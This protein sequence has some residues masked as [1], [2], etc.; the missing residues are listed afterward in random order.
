M[1]VRND[2]L[3]G[4]L[5]FVSKTQDYQIYGALIPDEMIN[6]DIKDSKAYKTYLDF[7]TRKSTPN[8]ARKFKKVASPSKKLSPVLE[9]EPAVKPKR[10]KKPTKKSTTVPTTDFVIKDTPSVS[11]LKKKA[12]TEA[13]RGK[14]IRSG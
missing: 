4:T 14:V 3:L 12:P 8:K 6:Q 9:E 5:K 11:V 1:I 10:A 13:D 2:T 7:A